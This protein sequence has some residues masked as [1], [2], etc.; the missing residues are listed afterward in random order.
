MS[1][2][3]MRLSCD[4][5]ADLKPMTPCVTPWSG[6]RAHFGTILSRSQEVEAC[7][8]CDLLKAGVQFLRQSHSLVQSDDLIWLGRCQ[9]LNYQSYSICVEVRAAEQAGDI[10]GV[11]EIFC[12]DSKFPATELTSPNVHLMDDYTC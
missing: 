6:S 10:L 12:C 11:F 3:D 9:D 5:C 2:G 7:G 1:I 8:F 4:L